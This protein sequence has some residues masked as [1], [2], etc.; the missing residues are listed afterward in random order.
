MDIYERLKSPLSSVFKL[1]GDERRKRAGKI[2]EQVT[3][4][5]NLLYIPRGQYHD[6]LA[7]QNGAIHIA[8]GLTYFKSIDAMTSFGKILF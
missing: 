3:L 5:W 6:A 2:I 8:F 1:S 4:R 7:S